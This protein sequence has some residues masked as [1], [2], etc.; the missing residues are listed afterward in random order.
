MNAPLR[1]PTIPFRKQT[2]SNGLDVIVHRDPRIPTVAVNL[3]YH[4]GSKDERH[5]QRGYAHLF[6][7]LM[8]EGSLHFPGDFFQPLQPLGASVNGSTSPDR[9]NYV[10]DLPTAHLELAMAME[11][12]RMAHLLPALTDEKLE[13]QKGVV[14]NEY[15]QNYG[16]RPY[17]QVT[18]LLSEALYP[19]DHPYHWPT[20]GAME[21]VRAATR[22]HVDAFFQRFYVPSN[23]S[24]CL[25]GELDEDQAFALAE[26]YFEPIPGGAPAIRPRVPEVEVPSGETIRLRDRV[27]LDRLHLVW[28]TVP[29]FHPDDAPLAMAAD[30]LSRGRSSRLY[31]RLVLE[32]QLAQNVSAYQSG[33]E[34]AGTF[35]VIVTLRPGQSWERAR[36]L[37]DAELADMARSVG[38]EELERARTRRLGGL[39]Y[40]LESLGGFGGVADR[41]NAFNVFLGD[42]GRITS[43]FERFEAVC[44]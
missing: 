18:R 9:T 5:G 34:L 15:R 12:D 22:A 21:D 16:N 25:V 38:L 36:E 29:Q 14:E 6:E 11:S 35:G 24:L 27:E 37:V 33:R 44:S 20:I 10:I 8:F 23:A 42:P 31:R 2:L 32:E 1:P 19:P 4:V 39:I 26:R 30:L 17:G 13:I 41:L 40:S 7:H 28:H 3:W 43:D